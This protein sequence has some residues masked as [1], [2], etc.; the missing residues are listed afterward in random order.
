[1]SFTYRNKQKTSKGKGIGGFL[2]KGTTKTSDSAMNMTL[3]VI[4]GNSLSEVPDIH[5]K[6]RKATYIEGSHKKSKVNMSILNQGD[7]MK[8]LY[9]R[10]RNY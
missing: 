4:Q 6:K 8:S 5:P 9:R 2:Q 7:Y 3:D 1:M 10:K